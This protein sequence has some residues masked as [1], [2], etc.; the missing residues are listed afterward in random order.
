MYDV[1]QWTGILSV[2]VT[3]ALGLA[4]LAFLTIVAPPLSL[5]AFAITC[6]LDAGKNAA[7]SYAANRTAGGAAPNETETCGNSWMSW[8]FGATMIALCWNAFLAMYLV[9]LSV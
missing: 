9:Y 8:V 6:I 2:C 4:A 7:F 5:P 3:V 1:A